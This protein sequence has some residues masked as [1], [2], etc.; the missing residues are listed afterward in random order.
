MFIDYFE[1]L[2]YKWPGSD[3]NPVELIQ[4]VGEIL[5]LFLIL[6]GVRKDCLITGGCLLLYQFTRRW[7]KLTVVVI[8]EYCY[9]RL[10]IVIIEEFRCYRLHIV[11]IEEYH[12]YQVNTT[13]NPIY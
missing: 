10:R 12:C 3:Q 1:L 11:I 2:V 13:V 6:F 8:E 5:G 4:V 7:A 9:Y